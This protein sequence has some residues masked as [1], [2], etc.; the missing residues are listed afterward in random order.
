MLC[1]VAM[2][3]RSGFVAAVLF[4][5]WTA[6]S[7]GAVF[8]W[9][10]TTD[11][12][13]KGEVEFEQW[14]TARWEKE[15]G[16]YNV[17]DFREE[18]EYGVTD[19]FQIALYLNHHYVYANSDVPVEDPAHPANRLRGVYETGGEDVRARHNPA[20]PFDDYRFESVSF[21]A[22]YRLLSPDKDPIG[23]AMYF[24]P[25]LGDDDKEL[26]WKVI[27]QKNWVEDRLVWALNLDYELEFE[28]A[29]NG[30]ERDGVFEWF[31]GISYRFAR[32]WSA[33]LEFW[34]HHKFADA[35]VH[36]HSAYFVGPTI[37][38]GGERWWATLGFL[39]QLPI[40]EALTKDN[41]EFA[42]HDGYIFGDEHEKY[43][44]RL[45]VGLDF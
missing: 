40:G 43:Y 13:S 20:T 10:Y 45:R 16:S 27:L 28:K 36:E 26:E 14:V 41:Q 2:K 15:H 5:A 6:Q 18:F 22:I 3:F 30:Y 33:G 11:V 25:T 42:A 39:H 8:A 12:A 44:V 32:N 17:I 38:Y 34:N 37:H 35:T 31:T 19:N 9:T 21:E 7:Y 29:A 4:C 1:I 23:L 24:E